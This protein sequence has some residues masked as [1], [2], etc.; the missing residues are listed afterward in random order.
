MKTIKLTKLFFSESKR[1]QGFTLIEVILATLVFSVGVL[2]F[3]QA[4][5]VALRTSEEAYWINWADLKNNELAERMR[6]CSTD[7]VC[8]R[9]QQQ[10]W[11]KE[12][13]EIFPQGEGYVTEESCCQSRISWFSTYQPDSV[14]A[15]ALHFRV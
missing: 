10:L 6:S 8:M 12:V 5:L 3:I 1:E 7:S 2:A 11:E 14:Q 13:N 4:E 15:L 9:Q